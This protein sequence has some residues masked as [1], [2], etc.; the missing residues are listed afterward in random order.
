ML[1]KTVTVPELILLVGTR[2]AF[3]VGAGL[4]IANKVNADVRKGAGVAL[5]IVAALTTIPIAI[6]MSS[7]SAVGPPEKATP[8][9]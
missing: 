1:E 9:A 3:G 7:K 4:L 8:T 2:V 5:M 6:A